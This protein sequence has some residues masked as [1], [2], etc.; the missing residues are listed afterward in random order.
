[1][2]IKTKSHLLG[3]LLLARILHL[4]ES[5]GQVFLLVLQLGDLLEQVLLVLLE[6]LRFLA[7]TL[8]SLDNL[9]NIG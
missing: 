3:H 1:M 4:L 7:L 2:K 6:T 5:L 9:L 8:I